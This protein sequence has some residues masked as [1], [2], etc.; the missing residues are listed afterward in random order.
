MSKPSWLESIE[1]LARELGCIAEQ[2]HAVCATAESCTAGLIAGAITQVPGSSAW[3]DRGFVTYSNAAKQ[4]MLGVGAQTLEQHGAVSEATVRQMAL[5]ALRQSDA[6]VSVAVSGIAGPAGAV[7]GKP[8]G[9]VC[10]GFARR[11]K[12]GQATYV[13]TQTLHFDG[14]RNEVRLATVH[15]A[16]VGL[17]EESAEYAR[18]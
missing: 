1:T 18:T 7:P 6:S 8:V 15:H 4:E 2:G 5:G 14:D 11:A 13:R 16:L 10:F 12:D 9:T 3:F 17:I